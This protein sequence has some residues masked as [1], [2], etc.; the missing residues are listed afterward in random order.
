VETQD[1]SVSAPPLLPPWRSDDGH[2]SISL[3]PADPTHYLVHEGS[4]FLMRGQVPSHEYAP[5]S[6]II[7]AEV[8]RASAGWDD[9][10]AG[11]GADA[12]DK[13]ADAAQDIADG[14]R[15]ERRRAHDKQ[16]A[17]DGFVK[18]S[19]VKSRMVEFLPGW[20]PYISIG[21]QTLLA[22]DP[23]VGKSTI[24]VALAAHVS[25]LGRNAVIMSAEDDHETKLR[26]LL[27]K[28]GADLDRCILQPIESAQVLN[29]QGLDKLDRAIAEYDPLLVTI[30]PVTYFLGG[31]KDMHRANEVR[32]VMK[33]L[34]AR[35]AMHQIAVVPLMHLNKGSGKALYRIL[36]SIDFPAVA[37]SAL[38]V[39]RVEDEPDRGRVLLHIKSNVGELGDAKGFDLVRDPSDK[40]RLPI[41][42]WQDTD[43]TEAD[44]TGSGSSAG[45]PPAQIST[46]KGIMVGMLKHGPQDA[47][48][49]K[50]A[51]LGAGVSERT[52]QRAVKEVVDIEQTFPGGGGSKSVWKLKLLDSNDRPDPDETA[53]WLSQIRRDGNV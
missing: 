13:W 47:A 19:A 17:S 15:A 34:S 43:L 29:E 38:L 10:P 4:A 26:P 48:V 8:A 23:G 46:A 41:F 22:G 5:A 50:A 6:L 9:S 42:K 7:P 21:H 24:A 32:D 40:H 33:E 52:L 44:I 20:D 16:L 35:A 3:D 18:A 51:V 12:F 14:L 27:E 30:D 36:G 28:M 2:F 11:L 49:V 31:D 53:A 45:R 39:G 37:R 25:R 1:H